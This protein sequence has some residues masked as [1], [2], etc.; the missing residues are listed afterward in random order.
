MGK[1]EVTRVRILEGAPAYEESFEG[2]RKACRA[3][4]E[5]LDEGLSE[6]YKRIF[7]REDNSVY[8]CDE[9]ELLIVTINERTN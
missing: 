1:F 8:L 4:K 5:I 9:N 3:Y 6:K 2:T 7:V